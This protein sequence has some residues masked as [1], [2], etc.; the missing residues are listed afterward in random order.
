MSLEFIFVR[1]GGRVFLIYSLSCCIELFNVHGWWP[2]N[3]WWMMLYL[4]SI[5]L[6]PPQPYIVA[7]AVP[8][9]SIAGSPRDIYLH[10]YNQNIRRCIYVSSHVVVLDSLCAPCVCV[11]VCVSTCPVCLLTLT[12][13]PG[14][15]IQWRDG[16]RPMIGSSF[17]PGRRRKRKDNQIEKQD[18]RPH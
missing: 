1:F 18:G 13:R 11:C 12:Y 7:A 16:W 14:T 6:Q 2:T 5:Y 17:S 8:P 3:W 15:W 10:E 9:I 4:I